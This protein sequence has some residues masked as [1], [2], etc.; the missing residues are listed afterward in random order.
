MS[1]RACGCVGGPPNPPIKYMELTHHSRVQFLRGGSA[2]RRREGGSSTANPTRK[3]DWKLASSKHQ[4]RHSHQPAAQH[5][6][7][8]AQHPEHSE[9][10][11]LPRS[12]SS[13]PQTI[14]GPQVYSPQKWTANS[15]QQTLNVCVHAG[16][17][18]FSDM[19]ACS[20]SV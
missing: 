4:Q 17:V 15:Q 16:N 6:S 10:G 2:P 12:S 13:E 20:V 14:Q 9:Q 3:Q 8:I 18:R 19:Q 7:L 1:H 5:A 11:V